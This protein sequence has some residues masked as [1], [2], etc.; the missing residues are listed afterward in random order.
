MFKKKVLSIV[1]LV[2]FTFTGIAHAIPYAPE[3]RKRDHNVSDKSVAEAAYACQYISQISENIGG[4]SFGI[5][6]YKLDHKAYVEEYGGLTQA[7]RDAMVVVV[8]GDLKGPKSLRG[9]KPMK[10]YITEYWA[11]MG[12][13]RLH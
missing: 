11:M 12:C 6:S 8:K 5:A 7:E 10:A 1:S 3:P 2:I 13:N 4:Y 9:R